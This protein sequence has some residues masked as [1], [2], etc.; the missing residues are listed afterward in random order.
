MATVAGMGWDIARSCFVSGFDAYQ[1]QGPKSQSPWQMPGDK[2]CGL[3]VAGKD[4]ARKRIALEQGWKA[5]LER[6]QSVM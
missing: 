1:A 2:R 6:E 4:A 5:F 3:W